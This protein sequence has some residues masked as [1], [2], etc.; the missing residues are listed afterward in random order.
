MTPLES[1]IREVVEDWLGTIIGCEA[2]FLTMVEER[3]TEG[4]GLDTVAEDFV[5]QYVDFDALMGAVEDAINDSLDA[6][7]IEVSVDWKREY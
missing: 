2:E 1:A 5:Q 3:I 4:D 7:A 6:L